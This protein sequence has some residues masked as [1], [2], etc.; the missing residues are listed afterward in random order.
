MH[1]A[2]PKMNSTQTTTTHAC[3]CGK[4][5]TTPHEHLWKYIDEW[6]G[7]AWWCL[8]CVKEGEEEERELMEEEQEEEDED[9]TNI[10]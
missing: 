4:T 8:E 6:F 2:L 1:L 3:E 10:E 9:P 5:T 7:G